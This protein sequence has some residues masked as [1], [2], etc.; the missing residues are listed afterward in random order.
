MARRPRRPPARRRPVA[1]AHGQQQ[2]DDRGGQVGQQI[3]AFGELDQGHQQHGG[4]NG[5]AEHRRLRLV[6]G[7]SPS[8]HAAV[9]GRSGGSGGRGAG[10]SPGIRGW[11]Q[12]VPTA[13]QVPHPEG[14]AGQ[15]GQRGQRGQGHGGEG[16]E[17]AE[18]GSTGR[19]HGRGSMWR[20]PHLSIRYGWPGPGAE[21][22]G[23]GQRH[24]D[25]PHTHG[26][27]AGHHGQTQPSPATG[28]CH[29]GNEGEHGEGLDHRLAE[30]GQHAESDHRGHPVPAAGTGPP[31]QDDEQRAAHHVEGVGG[32]DRATEPG[33]RAGGHDQARRQPDPSSAEV[34]AGHQGEP[35]CRGRGHR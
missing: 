29:H 31:G 34:P 27:G 30:P 8:D 19:R 12:V 22:A 35:G 17:R 26:E 24:G 4:D 20:A 13:D 2:G 21:A 5:R 18:V 10:V 16:G 15:D 3:P 7:P 25:Q 14:H 11:F 6:P 23:L 9:H 32:D 1:R 28:R 33:E